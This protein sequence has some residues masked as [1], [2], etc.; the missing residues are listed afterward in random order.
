MAVV[1]PAP[2]ADAVSTAKSLNAVQ[3]P[4]VTLKMMWTGTA[5]ANARIDSKVEEGKRPGWINEYLKAASPSQ[6]QDQNQPQS[7]QGVQCSKPVGII[8]FEDIIDAILQKTSWDEK[9]YFDRGNQAP[10]TK[11]KKAGDFAA[12]DQ[13]TPVNTVTVPKVVGII[14]NSDKASGTMRKRRVS[15]NQQGLFAMDGAFSSLENSFTSIHAPK[16]RE[17]RKDIISSNYTQNSDGGFHGS[18]STS[19][20]FD[21]TNIL[22]AEDVAELAKSAIPSSELHHHRIP[23]INFQTA[24]LPSRTTK[25]GGASKVS[26]Q[27]RHVS[28]APKLQTVNHIT[29]I[30]RQDYFIPQKTGDRVGDRSVLETNEVDTANANLVFPTPPAAH[31]DPV[32]S[33]SKA[34]YEAADP[35][36]EF[37]ADLEPAREHRREETGDTLSLGSYY[38]GHFGDDSL[39]QIYNASTVP[40]HAEDDCQ[41][42]SI[43]EPID[44]VT[45]NYEGFPPELLDAEDK[46]NR[47]SR[48]ASNTMPRLVGNLKE[49]HAKKRNVTPHREKSFHDDRALLPSQRKLVDEE[50]NI[51][52]SPRAS[53]LWF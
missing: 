5:K 4:S 23:Q 41:T 14:E 28:A 17:T 36:D 19:G 20:C 22:T 30:S 27:A 40:M 39:S 21:C 3:F 47:G 32:T 38:D 34:R 48:Y 6:D 31:V 2:K 46:E 42:R 18:A 51:V 52:V 44:E 43:L 29:S 10:G 26:S 53:S 45:K 16:I 8:T 9:D 15:K 13:S 49:E 25:N 35:F 11:S 12:I 24:S 37:F 33:Y 7:I 50:G 1:V